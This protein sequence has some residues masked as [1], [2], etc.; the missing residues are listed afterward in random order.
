MC[1]RSH[2]C[3]HIS[4]VLCALFFFFSVLDLTAENNPPRPGREK[5]LGRRTLRACL[6]GASA[7]TRPCRRRPSGSLDDLHTSLRWPR[8][9][10]PVPLHRR[11]R[12]SIRRR[13]SRGRPSDYPLLATPLP[14]QSTQMGCGC[15]AARSSCPTLRVVRSLPSGP[16]ALIVWPW[17]SPRPQPVR[18]WFASRAPREH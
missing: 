3:I 9:H 11:T 10:D 5:D 17:A 16:A 2:R 13:K 14:I 6:A 4:K 8:N 12:P 18:L 1:G 15:A 7:P